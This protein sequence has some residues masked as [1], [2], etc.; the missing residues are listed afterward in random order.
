MEGSLVPDNLLDSDTMKR[1]EQLTLVSRKM[2]TGKRK[3]ERRTRHRGASTDFAD[4][5]NYVAGDDLRFLDWKIY[6]RL[7]RLFI[8]LFLEEEDLRVHLL[9]D[10]SPSMQFGDPDKFLY[11]RR[12]A[13]A[14]GYICLARM[15]CLSARSFGER[16]LESYGPRRG[17]VNSGTFFRF[18]SSLRPAEQTHLS[19]CLKTFAQASGRRGVAVVI[20]DFYDFEGYE[21]GLRHLIA[22]DFEVLAVHVLSHEELHPAVQG[23]IRLVDSEVGLT[24]DVS[25]G[26]S[27]L[28]SYERTLDAFCGGLKDY[29]V[30][31]GGSY[32]LTSTR[33]PFE[34]L[35]L[36]VLR[37]RGILR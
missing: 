13:A 25:I 35:I 32:L 33:M 21:E 4:Y 10:A 29:I 5:R 11:A 34:R 16:L 7:E 3:G 12:T 28:K 20:S 6:G 1:L 24:T 9:I 15:D 17:K 8:K 27:L 31:R 26:R 36:E 23:D 2:A 37:R 19:A 18:L 22:A 14:L 30:S